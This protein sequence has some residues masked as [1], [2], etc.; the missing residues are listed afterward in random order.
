MTL[1][2]E[3][4]ASS[5]FVQ[6]RKVY[7]H[8]S[9][10]LLS[11]LLVVGTFLA[12]L[13][14][15]TRLLGC[16]VAPH[17]GQ[18]VDI[19]DEAAL[20]IW[21]AKSKTEHFIRRARFETDAEDFGFLV[22]TPTKPDLGEAQDW[23][24]ESLGRMT[25][26]RQ[27]Y[28]TVTKTVWGFESI[29][30]SAIA[31]TTKAT[32]NAV[33]VLDRKQVAGFDATVLRAD[34]AAAL[35]EWLGKHGY[36]SRPELTEWLQ[37]YVEHQW[38]ITAFK[39]AKGQQ[40]TFEAKSVRIS[41]Q[42]E[43]PIYPYREPADSR[44]PA[45]QGGRTLRVFMLADQR[46]QGTL[47]ESGSWPAS[48]A[49]AKNIGD[50]VKAFVGEVNSEGTDFASTLADANY[51]TEFEDRS[52]PR[53]GTDEVYFRPSPD[54]SAKERP[55]VIHTIDVIE[56]WPGAKGTLVL[57]IA[58]PLALGIVLWKLRANMLQRKPSA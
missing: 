46:Y 47:G 16:A 6:K 43:M 38:I 50:S 25:A 23:V 20:I 54:Q 19:R 24:F 18:H 51:L 35:A 1:H 12:M 27:E 14:G 17:R 52:F 41:F 28:Q 8:K 34:D 21:H 48:T 10:V 9:R 49:W 37:W 45:Q 57:V 4:T 2:S 5:G 26:A 58:V 56:Y 7:M 42:T 13:E 44:Q 30:R 29:L 15:H 33:E 53:P 55:P 31:P 22:P 11:S 39:L 40:P 32:P 36:E 3:P